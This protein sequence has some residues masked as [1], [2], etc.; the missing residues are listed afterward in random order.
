MSRMDWRLQNISVWQECIFCVRKSIYFL[1]RCQYV[2]KACLLSCDEMEI[3]DRYL[4]QLVLVGWG[5]LLIKST[6]LAC[7]VLR[8][9]V[10]LVLGVQQMISI[11]VQKTVSPYLYMHV[12]FFSVTNISWCKSLFLVL[13]CLCLV[14][15][16]CHIQYKRIVVTEFNKSCLTDPVSSQEQLGSAY[17]SSARADASTRLILFI[18]KHWS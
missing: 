7:S 16:C 14:P 4:V 12:W 2:K 10:G 3:Q 9:C 8:S 11:V 17:T 5:G 13:W 6:G 1:S 15:I 18:L